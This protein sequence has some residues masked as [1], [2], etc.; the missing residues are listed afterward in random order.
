VKFSPGPYNEPFSTFFLFWS[1]FYWSP[2]VFIDSLVTER[3]ANGSIVEDFFP[4]PEALKI[5]VLQANCLLD[6]HSFLGFA[7]VDGIKVRA[8]EPETVKFF[9]EKYPSTTTAFHASYF[10]EPPT[11]LTPF[12][13]RLWEALSRTSGPFLS[14]D[15]GLDAVLALIDIERRR[16]LLA[17]FLLSVQQ[18]HEE[19]MFQQ[20][21]HP[22][23]VDWPREIQD[24]VN[25]VRSEQDNT[26]PL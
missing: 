12:V 24:A 25:K 15:P 9:K 1:H 17:R 13:V 7:K 4:T 18:Q 11:L 10:H 26:S 22:Y 5:S 21:R 23:F 8:G 20:R 6:W 19:W 16:H 3:Y 2:N 14:L